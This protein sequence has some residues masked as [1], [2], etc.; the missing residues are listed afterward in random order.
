MRA[1]R[2]RLQDILEAIQKIE[3][4]AEQGEAAFKKDELLQTWVVHHIE[5][6]GEATRGVSSSLRVA[7]PEIPWQEL[8]VLRNQLVHEYFVID[9]DEVWRVVERDLPDLK[10]K[11]EVILQ[12]LVP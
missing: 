9:A 5:L 8:I 10:R 4:Y 6:I 2:D 3:R 7:H 1:D 12:S 11:I